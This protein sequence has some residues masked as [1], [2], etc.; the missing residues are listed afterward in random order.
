LTRGNDSQIEYQRRKDHFLI[1][2]LLRFVMDGVAKFPFNI[3]KTIY[4]CRLWL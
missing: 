2:A 1:L 4:A 3:E